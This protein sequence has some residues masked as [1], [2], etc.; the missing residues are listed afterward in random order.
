MPSD[1][2]LD[3]AK[4]FILGSREVPMTGDPQTL[5]TSIIF[6]IFFIYLSAGT[7]G[8]PLGYSSPRPS[9]LL[10]CEWNLGSQ[11][12]II[13]HLLISLPEPTLALPYLLHTAVHTTRSLRT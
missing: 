10:K 2:L 4:S 13:S 11:V 7:L 3:Q 12:A 1:I 9:V 8:S 6:N 5:H